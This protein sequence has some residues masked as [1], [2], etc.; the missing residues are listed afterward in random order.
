[1][2]EPFYGLYKGFCVNNNDPEGLNRITATCP[3]VFT[4]PTVQTDWAWP[5]IP[6]G[7]SIILPAPNTGVW[8]G[9]EGGDTQYPYWAGVWSNS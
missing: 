6:S 3:T 9:F 2:S 4:D 5:V 7:L 1:M 8:I